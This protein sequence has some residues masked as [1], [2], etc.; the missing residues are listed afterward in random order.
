MK[1]AWDCMTLIWCASE[2]TS[3]CTLQG[4]SIKQLNPS[5][6]HASNGYYVNGTHKLAANTT[7]HLDVDDINTDLANGLLGRLQLVK[8]VFSRRLNSD[9]GTS[10]KRQRDKGGISGTYILANMY[11]CKPLALD[12]KDFQSRTVHVPPTYMYTTTKCCW[13]VLDLL[14]WS[15]QQTK[16]YLL[17]SITPAVGH[18]TDQTEQMGCNNWNTSW[19]L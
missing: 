11:N 14:Q 7:H 17:H 2:S 5:P 16:R 15:L 3:I 9:G 1:T 4:N 6:E 13:R 12:S 19:L 8:T 10:N 18:K